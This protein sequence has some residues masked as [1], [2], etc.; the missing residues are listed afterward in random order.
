MKAQRNLVDRAHVGAFDDRAEF[1]VAEQRDLALDVFRDRTFG[2]DDEN[3]RLNTDLHQLA[4]RVLRGLGLELTGR[5]DVRH[6]REVNEDRVLAA[7]VVAEL[8]DGFEKRQRLDVADRA[9]NFD[10]HDVGLRR[11]SLD[12]SS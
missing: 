5:G 1:H 4:H 10:D 11:H 8:T 9:A 7:D 3:V 2:A 12:R 6:Q